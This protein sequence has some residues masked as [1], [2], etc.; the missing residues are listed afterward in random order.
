MAPDRDLPYIDTHELPVDAPRD[1]VWAALREY[2]DQ[3]LASERASRLGLLLGAEPRS[4]F[5]VHDEVPGE[6]VELR[7]RHRFSD[8]RLVFEVSDAGGRTLLQAHSY[9]VF[10][11][12]RGVLYRTAVIGSRA[13]VVAT[14]HLLRSI[15]KRV[16]DD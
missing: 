16:A 3:A 5:A 10:P 14:R 8:Y 11:G 13:H 1:R 12:V 9:A 4:G 15:A 7:G 6:R 2:V